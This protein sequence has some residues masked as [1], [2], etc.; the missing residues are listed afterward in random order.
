MCMSVCQHVSAW[1]ST[2]KSCLLLCYK[3]ENMAAVF[4][5]CVFFSNSPVTSLTGGLWTQCPPAAEWTNKFRV[6]HYSQWWTT[7][8]ESG[9]SAY[10]ETQRSS[11]V[12]DSG[13]S[14]HHLRYQTSGTSNSDVVDSAAA[15][16]RDRRTKIKKKYSS[17]N[18][19]YLFII[20]Y[21]LVVQ[22]RSLMN[23]WTH[24]PFSAKI[25]KH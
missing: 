4:M 14:T 13:F 10:E 25:F 2:Q 16:D 18:S 12:W 3:K 1:V 11:S 22:I 19:K 23:A 9:P 21:D 15:K 20:H 5:A 24:E 7:L 8:Q 6:V 17:K